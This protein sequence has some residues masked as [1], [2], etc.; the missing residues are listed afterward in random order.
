MV[1]LNHAGRK[2]S[3]VRPLAR[4]CPHAAADGRRMACACAESDTVPD[5]YR[6]RVKLSLIAGRLL[7][8]LE[9]PLL[10]LRVPVW[11]RWK[12]IWLMATLISSIFVA[13]LE[14]SN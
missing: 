10:A 5:T 12:S 8:I 9:L 13:A 7:R 3:S 4:A 2:G 11:M 14:P 1:Q 6:R